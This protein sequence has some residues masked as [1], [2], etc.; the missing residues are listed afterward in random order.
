MGYS[1]WGRK[2]SDTTEVTFTLL[3]GA[4]ACTGQIMEFLGIHNHVSWFLLL[5]ET[6]FSK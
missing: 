2:E 6:S 3:S 4:P 1:P 5:I